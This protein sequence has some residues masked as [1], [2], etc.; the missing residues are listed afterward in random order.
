MYDVRHLQAAPPELGTYLYFES[1][2]RSPRWGWRFGV[3][4]GR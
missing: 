4:D 2:N 3:L 1:T